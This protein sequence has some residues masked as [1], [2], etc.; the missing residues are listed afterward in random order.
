M[1]NAPVD[2]LRGV[3]ITLV[4]LLHYSLTYRLSKSVLADLI[5][6]DTVRAIVNN[7]NCGVTMFFVVSGYLNTSNTLQRFGSLAAVDVRTFYVT[8]A[9]RI[10]P[11]LLLALAVI[12]AM[13]L[14]GV[15][16][17]GNGDGSKALPA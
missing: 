16:S 11:P 12:V 7:G 6:A 5:G 9:A 17:F 10:L 3:A 2:V 8:R 1:R 4:L 14:A 13:G 15:P